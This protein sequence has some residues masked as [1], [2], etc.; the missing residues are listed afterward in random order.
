MDDYELSDDLELANERVGNVLKHK[1]RLD[2]LIATGGAAAVYAATHRNGM[3]AAIKI[4]HPELSLHVSTRRRFLR[5]GYVANT[6]EHPGTVRVLDDDVTDDGATF[7]V[8]ELLDGEPLDTRAWRHEGP[9]PHGD[10]LYIAYHLLDALAAAHAKGIIHRD[11]KPGNIVLTRSGQVKVLDFGIARLTDAPATT[12]AVSVTT[13][14]STMGTPAF[15]PPE[16][17]KGHW[18]EVDAR[19]DIWAVGATMFLLLTGKYVH[20]AETSSE[21]LLGAM[22]K[23][24]PALSSV[25]ADIP[26]PVVRLV[27]RALAYE[28]AD[29]WPDAETMRNAVANVFK[30]LTGTHMDD[31]A[32]PTVPPPPPDSAPDI[33]MTDPA[34]M[35]S[36]TGATTVATVVS[37]PDVSHFRP[38]TTNDP[39]PGTTGK[40]RALVIGVS[41]LGVV[42]V[43]AIVAFSGVMRSDAESNRDSSLAVTATAKGTATNSAEAARPSPTNSTVATA[44]SATSSTDPSSTATAQQTSK[45]A[46]TTKAKPLP[47]PDKDH[48]TDP[49]PTVTATGRPKP[50]PA[51]TTPSKT[52]DPADKWD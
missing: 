44:A 46:S 13:H 49:P 3:R 19:S 42:A 5:E 15:M 35:P 52:K 11:I 40:R 48:Q 12:P 29:R 17:A 34:T 24:A 9:L 45:P 1:W 20:H 26:E 47:R 14:G 32:S 21:V 25:N 41:S 27:D 30:E 50:L 43:V 33:E 16:Q 51:T 8:M 4:L 6:V 7:L 38:E 31:A 10:V 39:V 36:S 28:M 23:A 37:K 18:N 22:T 2:Y